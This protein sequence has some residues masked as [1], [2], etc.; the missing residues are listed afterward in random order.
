M[1]WITSAIAWAQE[2]LSPFINKFFLGVL[3]LLVG[4]IIG[5]VLS[6]FVRQF[7]KSADIDKLVSQTSGTKVPLSDILSYVVRYLIYF[8]FLVLALNTI[9]LTSMILTATAFIALLI[10]IL[11]IFLGIKDFIPNA[12]AGFMIQK[13]QFI[14]KGDW[15]CFDS[16][17]GEVISINLTDTHVKT[18]TGDLICTPNVLLNNKEIRKMSKPV[19]KSSKKQVRKTSKKSS[20]QPKN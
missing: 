20:S 14:K 12:I 1:S 18:D 16:V 9:G 3:L 10:V 8:L 15:I 17:C 7:L 19:K 5:R 11:S 6:T 2:V 4:I 13:K